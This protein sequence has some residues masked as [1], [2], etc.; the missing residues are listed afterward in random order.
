MSWTAAANADGYKVQW[1]LEDEAYD[2][3]RQAVVGA[4]T[5]TY[6]IGELTPGALYAVRVIATREHAPDGEPSVEAAGTPEAANRPPVFAEGN[7]ATRSLA[8]NA[9]AGEAVGLA[10]EASDEDG[11]PLTYHLEGADAGAF[12][13]D[14]AS[15][16]LRTRTGVSYDFEAKAGYAVRVRVEDGRGGEA[17]IE[18]AVSLTDEEEPPG[19]PEAPVLG[20]AGPA[21]LEVSWGE[22][23]NTGPPVTGYEVGY[24]EGESG[25]YL[26]GNHQGTGRSLRLTGLKPDTA[27]QAR[28][29]A[30]N[31]EGTGPWSLPGTGRTEQNPPPG[32]VAGVEVTARTEALEV[33]W[34]AAA[35]ADGYR[36]QWRLENEAY[37]ETRQ[38]VVGAGTLTYTIGELTPGAAYRVRVIA[39]REHAPDGEPSAEATGTP[40]AESPGAVEGVEV[41]PQTGALEV[42]WTAAANADGYKVEWRLENEAYDETRQAVVGAG[43]LTYTIGE[44]TP[45]ALYRVRVIATRE[46]ALDGEPSAEATGT[47]RAEAPGAVE[48]VE[49]TPQT[50]ALEVRWGAVEHAGGYKVQWRLED[51]AY[52]E[53][54]QA[55]VGAGT[56]TY[57]IGELTPGA[58]YAVRVIATREHAPDGEPSA[59]ASGTP[60][61]EAPGRVEGLEVEAESEALEVSWTVIEHAGGYKVQWRL[62]SQAYDETRQAVVGGGRRGQTRI[63]YLIRDL[64]PGADY[65]VRVIATREHALDGEPSAEASGTPLLTSPGT[66]RGVRVWPRTEALQVEWDPVEL[67]DGY[68]VQWRFPSDISYDEVRQALVEGDGAGGYRITDL[69]ADVTYWVRVTATRRGA[70]DGFPSNGYAGRPLPGLEAVEGVRVR[71]LSGALRVE[72]DPT[73]ASDGHRVEW[74][75]GSEDWDPGRQGLAGRAEVSYTITD[76]EADTEYRVRVTAT[77]QDD[78]DGPPSE[79]VVGR[80]RARAGGVTVTPTR[81]TIAEGESESYTLVLD[82]APAAEVT[83]S[84]FA[85]EGLSVDRFPVFTPTDWSTPQTV[86]VTPDEDEDVDDELYRITHRTAS[87]DAHY[88]DLGVDAVEVEV[89]DDDVSEGELTVSASRLRITE[90]NTGRYTVVLN[91]QPSAPVTVLVSAPEG[92]SLTVSPE[93][94]TFTTANWSTPQTVTV[95]A[96]EDTDLSDEVLTISHLIPQASVAALRGPGGSHAAFATSPLPPA[97]REYVY[98]GGRLAVIESGGTAGEIFP[99]FAAGVEVLIDDD[100]DPAT[101]GVSALTSSLRLSEG[102]TGSYSV[103]LLSQPRAD[104]TITLL[105]DPGP[106]RVA[107]LTLSAPG[108]PVDDETP[109]SPDRL[110][111]TAETWDAPQWVNLTVDRD[112]DS[113]DETETVNHAVTSQDLDYD[114][115]AVP[116]VRVR[117]TDRYSA[118]VDPVDPTGRISTS[119]DSCSIDPGQETCTTTLT[120]GSENTQ[121][122]QIRR[123][124]GVQGSEEY[125]IILTSDQSSGSESGVAVHE[126]DNTFELWDYDRNANQGQGQR[127]SRLDSVEVTGVTGPDLSAS[128]N[129]CIIPDGQTTCKVTLTWNSGTATRIQIRQG[130]TVVKDSTES[131]GTVMKNLPEGTH[132]FDLYDYSGGSRGNKLDSVTVTVTTGPTISASPNPCR[133]AEGETTCKTTVSWT[134]QNPSRVWV[135]HGENSPFGYVGTLTAFTDTDSTSGS[136]EASIREFPRFRSTFQLRDHSSGSRG[137][138]LASVN[139]SGTRANRAPP[140]PTVSDQTARVGT[141]FS[142]QFAAVTD[143]DGDTVTYSA[144]Y[145]PNKPTWLSFDAGKR[146][147]SGTPASGHVRQTTVTVKA[148]DGSLSSSSEFTLTVSAANRAP[149][150]PTVSDQTARVG[151][152]FSY[153]FAAVT[154]PDGDTVTYSA[155]YSPNKPTWLSFDAGKRTFS[156]TPASGHVRQ[157]TVTVK[158]SDGSLSS[159]SEFTLTVSAANR[160]PPAPTVSDQTARVGTAFSYQFAA[161]TDP[162]GDTVTYSATYSPNKPTWLSFDAGKR[163]FSGTPASGH[164]RQTTVT[165][166]AS[167]GSLSSSSEF[168]LTVSAVDPPAPTCDTFSADRTTINRCQPVTLS[169]TTS[170]ADSAELDPGNMSVP[171]DSS[172]SLSPT[173]TTTYRLTAKGSGTQTDSC[174]AV[175][176]TVN[177]KPTG[178]ISASPNPCQIQPGQST[179]TTTLS[180]S[181]TGTTGLRV[182]VSRDGAAARL[183]SSSGAS[184]SASP[185]WIREGSSY[186]FSLYDYM[187]RVK[188]CLL[189]SVTVSGTRANRAPTA[190]AGNDQTVAEGASV[191]LSGSGTDPENQTLTYSWKQTGGSP[192]VTLSNANTATASFTAPTQLAQS[193]ALTFTLTVSDG[194]LSDTDDVTVTVTAG[195][196]PPVITSLSRIQGNPDTEVTIYGAHFGPDEGTVSF[197]G[198]SATINSWSNTSVRVLV[199]GRLSRGQVTLSLTRLDGEE[200]NSV[201]FWVIGDPVR[202]EEDCEEGDEEC[203]EE[204]EDGEDCPEEEDEEDEAEDEEDATPG[205]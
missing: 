4:G 201:N 183:V 8:E 115:I 2:E 25:A 131:S 33:S 143:P 53:T 9:A 97:S 157:T 108:L 98:L 104:V 86:T 116:D 32:K 195:V 203:D 62:E 15:G 95:T 23:A 182:E 10:V 26:D 35:N 56:L 187:D 28:V 66:V 174:P 114:G 93:S 55:V 160:A 52:D 61:A 45:G 175:T 90:G 164:V 176:V 91:R 178:T 57:T 124:R 13:I 41:T 134:S 117:I 96:A 36:V 109:A 43:T 123:V 186:V 152:A 198:E 19:A 20:E 81:L 129:P 191:I 113:N 94:L 196:S 146:T 59:E 140:A 148:S 199:P 159:S 1:R 158:A 127:K 14:A 102:H 179:C 17:S 147:F 193:T 39:T 130:S 71:S 161:V 153:Q 200:S 16:Q 126:G 125:T 141:A 73:L 48:G 184:G 85:G 107:D 120:W 11:D 64:T 21:G 202:G 162:D 77:R 173:S 105:I 144:T 50:E 60:R 49:V 170:N 172:K 154:D 197:G 180:W 133:I 150:A 190:D 166:K 136:K 111:F 118:P 100:D 47:P 87:S 139:V 51:Q 112:D 76:L 119:S 22:P 27:Y 188:G 169:W 142:Y 30:S 42:R 6:T 82:S 83:V 121:T 101:P 149:P 75:T 69:E 92:G 155:T 204:C 12:G 72:W 171:V 103:E 3:T 167:D 38:A 135:I 37:D 185:S 29:R 168:T 70:K 106:D 24:R 84:V 18:V 132:T 205:P 63:G 88:H 163:T 138:V 110:V 65:T 7:A 177:P 165:V 80:T 137:P 68:K 34:T 5:L 145:S 192:T 46:H 58:L 156:G 122:V 79:E 67:A 128:P 189:A 54:R 194:S 181:A 74:R 99:V 151:T 31:A 78:P 44:L 89:E 40:R